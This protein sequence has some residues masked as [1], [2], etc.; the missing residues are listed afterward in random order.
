MQLFNQVRIELETLAWSNGA[1]LD[2]A[3]FCMRRF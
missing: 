3:L 1:D 2:P